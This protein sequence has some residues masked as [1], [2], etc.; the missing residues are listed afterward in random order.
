MNVPE[1]RTLKAALEKS[2]RDELASF[3]RKSGLRVKAVE[4]IR[5]DALSN[6]GFSA[7]TK[8]DIRIIAEL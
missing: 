2:I 7:L 3:T 1:M 5:T 4:C 6:D 8:Y